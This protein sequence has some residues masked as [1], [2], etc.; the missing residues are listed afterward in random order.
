M[1]QK[2]VIIGDGETAEMAFEYL[3]SEYTIVAF[4]VEKEF[5]I[6]D[7]KYGLPITDFESLAQ[8]YFVEDIKCFVAVSYNQNNRL[9]ERL[10]L[11]VKQ[12]GYTCVSF[13]HPSAVISPFATIGENCFILEQVVV[14]RKVTI[15][16][17]VFIWSNSTIA[18]QSS[19]HDHVFLATSSVVSGFCKIGTRSFIGAGAVLKDSIEIESD[20]I[21]GAGSTVV[22]KAIQSK[23][24]IG[25]PAKELIK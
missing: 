16:N 9:R 18:H 3:N 19:I 21:I 1:K 2:I 22:N 14:Q 7:S 15:G 24:Y 11:I 4:L 8:T 12:L 17:N 13:V 5:R 23:T 20:V 10:Y 6:S 25:I